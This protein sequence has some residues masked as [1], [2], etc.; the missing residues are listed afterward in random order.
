MSRY[1]FNFFKKFFGKDLQ[2]KSGSMAV[3]FQ[4]VPCGEINLRYAKDIKKDGVFRRR[5][6]PLPIGAKILK[7]HF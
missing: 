2:G 3:L 7:I 4:F 5:K 1:F 6:S